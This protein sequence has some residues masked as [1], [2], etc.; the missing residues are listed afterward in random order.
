MQ[1]VC[2]ALVWMPSLVSLALLIHSA[3]STDCWLTDLYLRE[4]VRAEHMGPCRPLCPFHMRG[5]TPAVWPQIDPY[6]QPGHFRR[7]EILKRRSVLKRRWTSCG[8]L[9][10][11]ASLIT[12]KA[13]IKSNWMDQTVRTLLNE[14][15]NERRCLF[16]CAHTSQMHGDWR[17]RGC[18]GWQLATGFR[19][20]ANGA[21]TGM[22]QLVAPSPCALRQKHV[23]FTLSPSMWFCF[24]VISKA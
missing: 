4:V 19:H 15:T 2:P 6:K 16:C 22:S 3:Q 1:I 7:S 24:E 17:F 23:T 10:D 9:M 8:T 14:T 12:C 11:R 5:H 20:Q 18:R 13:R 21:S